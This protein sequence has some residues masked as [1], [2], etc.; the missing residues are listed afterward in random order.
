MCRLELTQ[1]M[2]LLWNLIVPASG[3][4]PPTLSVL[5]R[6]L[7]RPDAAKMRMIPVHGHRMQTTR[8]TVL[9]TCSNML[10]AC[11]IE[12]TQVVY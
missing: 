10:S 8:K 11:S 9:K 5:S 6:C 4:R 3:G 2:A 1:C 7:V 12:S